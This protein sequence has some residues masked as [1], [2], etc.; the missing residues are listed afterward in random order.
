MYAI[1]Y[2]LYMKHK[3]VF[4]SIVIGICLSCFQ[5]VKA[6][7]ISGHLKDSSGDDMP[8]ATIYIENDSG[9]K[10]DKQTDGNG[11]F[12]FDLDDYG[13]ASTN[14]YRH[15]YGNFSFQVDGQEID[16]IV[17]DNYSYTTNK[18][19]EV[20]ALCPQNDENAL[21]KIININEQLYYI[22]NAQSGYGTNNYTFTCKM[23]DNENETDILEKNRAS[24]QNN[25]QNV[26]N[27]RIMIMYVKE[28]QLLS[29]KAFIG[30][31]DSD[32]GWASFILIPEDKDNIKDNLKDR[33]SNMIWNK[34]ASNQF[35]KFDVVEDT[36]LRN[37]MDKVRTIYGDVFYE[38]KN[39]TNEITN[40]SIE[41][42]DPHNNF[43]T[44]DMTIYV[45]GDDVTPPTLPV[46]PSTPI[47][48]DIEIK[49][50]SLQYKIILAD[51]RDISQDV[52]ALGP[53]NI[54]DDQ[55][56]KIDVDKELMQGM[57]VRL[58]G[59]I[60]IANN[61]PDDTVTATVASDIDNMKY[62]E[63]CELISKDEKNIDQ[64]W[65][66]PDSDE[67]NKVAT[68][69]TLAPGEEKEI[70]IAMSQLITSGIDP[71]YVMYFGIESGEIKMCKLSVT[72][73]TGRKW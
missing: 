46:T 50:V 40:N 44:E 55:L 59:K 19:V 49:E 27:I 57:T 34:K 29:T 32:N 73:P 2:C 64:G 70:S 60:K 47:S 25:T 20:L 11:Y 42:G 68:Y 69:V 21:N 36:S 22:F 39:G 3:I 63:N 54:T 24:F 16:K 30:R 13:L 17:Q 35:T 56:Y 51:G 6:T 4:L 5:T 62:D 14:D 8:N 33:I 66:M 15:S 26:G 52:F 1:A 38:N 72:P 53:N 23:Y 31:E 18:N 10:F 45:K 28:E 65:N 61:N 43:S 37:A 58:E 41:I 71:E 12:E 48:N 67:P 7:V 9:S